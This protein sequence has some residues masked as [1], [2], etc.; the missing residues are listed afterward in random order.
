MRVAVLDSITANCSAAFL[1]LL[2]AFVDARKFVRFAQS[3]ET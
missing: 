2:L 1:D 3:S